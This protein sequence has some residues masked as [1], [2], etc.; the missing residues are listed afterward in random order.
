MS[1][2]IKEIARLT[3]LSVP[4]VGNVLGRSADRYSAETR[5]R[6]MEAARELG[7]RPNSSAR[8]MRQGRT[9]CAALVLSRSRQQTHSY[10]PAGLLDGL[11]DELALE[12]GEVDDV[13]VDGVLAP[14]LAAE[15]LAIAQP[16][17]EQALGVR[18]IGSQCA[19][20]PRV[21]GS[22]C[23]HAPHP[24]PLPTP[25]DAWGEGMSSFAS[26]FH[27]AF[28]RDSGERSARSAG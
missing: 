26:G 7:Y 15:Q 8:A 9:G 16:G 4:T 1:V 18:G 17:P 22:C 2:T 12:A 24:N 21:R 3:G 14:E 25:E 6:V 28:P 10:S 27:L 19:S 23:S 13:A 5:R 20:Q 11:D